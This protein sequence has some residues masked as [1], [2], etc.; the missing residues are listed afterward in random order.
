MEEHPR[1]PELATLPFVNLT[2][3]TNGTRKEYCHQWYT[4]QYC[5]KRSDLAGLYD[6]AFLADIDEFLWMAHV[7]A[8]TETPPATTPTVAQEI[9]QSYIQRNIT[10]IAFGKYMYTLD[11]RLMMSDEETV[12]CRRDARRSSAHS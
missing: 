6:W 1:W 7:E 4:E 3:H 9:L 11:H 8:T 2:L 10:Y 12:A 5:L